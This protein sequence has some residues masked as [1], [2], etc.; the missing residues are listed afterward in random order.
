MDATDT[1]PEHLSSSHIFSG[2]P[3]AQSLVFCVMFCR[4][5]I[6][7]PFVLLHLTIA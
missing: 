1:L 5:I 7:L 2:I 3:A 4:S 6:A